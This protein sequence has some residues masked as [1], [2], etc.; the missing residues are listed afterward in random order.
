[1][2]EALPG[3]PLR[4]LDLCCG[5]GVV[6][7]QLLESDLPIERLTLADLSPELMRRA[8][9]LLDKRL[10]ADRLP[11]LDTVEI[12]LLVDD[13]AEHTEGKYD[14]VVTCNAFQHFPRERQAE[15]FRQIHRILGPSGV[16]VF[17][18]HFK[19]VRPAW[20][21]YLVDSYQAQLRRHGAPE[22]FVSDAA[23]HIHQFHNYI[24]LRDAYEWLE[25]AEF[26]FY[27]CTFRKDE[28]GIFAA[29]R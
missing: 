5:V 26:G 21:Q 2:A 9:A 6:A 11:P 20:K 16:F 14:L 27:E 29:V 3:R 10:G 28:I 1:M 24:N 7:L 23:D 22:Q 17:G 8:S 25:A 18:S 19:L 12:D 4:V 13:L 15:L